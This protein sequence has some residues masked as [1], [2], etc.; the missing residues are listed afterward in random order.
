M[1][2]TPFL[3]MS[4]ICSSLTNGPQL[5]MYVELWNCEICGISLPI[6][7]LPP[8][9]A[10]IPIPLSQCYTLHSSHTLYALIF[11]TLALLTQTLTC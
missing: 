9:H 8:P 10:G 1:T 5:D 3:C 7:P 6:C 11:L 4:S 2:N